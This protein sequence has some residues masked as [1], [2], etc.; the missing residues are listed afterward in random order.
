M[1]I[2]ES[3]PSFGFSLTTQTQ[4]QLPKAHAHR[5]PLRIHMGPWVPHFPAMPNF[6]AA[7]LPEEG[8]YQ[9]LSYLSKEDLVRCARVCKIWYSHATPFIYQNIDF[10]WYHPRSICVHNHRRCIC[11]RLGSCRPEHHGE[12]SYQ[13]SCI[14]TFSSALRE[15]PPLYLFFRTVISSPYLASHVRTLRLDGTVPSSIWTDPQQTELSIEDR[16]CV[17]RLLGSVPRLRHTEEYWMTELDNG[18]PEAFAATLLLALNDLRKIDIGFDFG[19]P[20]ELIGSPTILSCFV[21]LTTISTGTFRDLIHPFNSTNGP[22]LPN[23]ANNSRIALFSLPSLR[24][25]SINMPK[26]PP[27][28]A[29]PW[30]MEEQAPTISNLKTLELAFTDLGGEPL[31]RLLRCCP[32][33]YD[34][35]YDFWTTTQESREDCITDRIN[36]QTLQTTL[37]T[38]KK[39]LRTLHLHI[40][41]SAWRTRQAAQPPLPKPMS[42]LCFADF[43]VLTTL[44]VSVFALTCQENGRKIGPALPAS[45]VDLWLNDDM[46]AWPEWHDDPEPDYDGYY[47]NIFV[48]VIAEYLYEWRVFTPKLKS[49][50]VLVTQMSKP[51]LMRRV[52][53][54]LRNKLTSQGREA[55]V[56]VEVFMLPP[57]NDWEDLK[58]RLL[59]RA[60]GPPYFDLDRVDKFQRIWGEFVARLPPWV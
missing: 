30:S 53:E 18:S 20:L 40:S 43:G 42:P 10:V 22:G 49:L 50:K 41:H 54:T 46:M 7:H 57:R 34:L 13:P 51:L 17:R 56:E 25:L 12:P 23:T 36:L 3:L 27:A 32:Q 38:V 14:E 48:D 8:Y 44:H 5:I 6:G 19:Q 15:Y 1:Q 55:G 31:T 39:M 45:L 60:C 52:T 47:D 11:A 29:F 37:S 2:V 33:L 58:S 9:V 28:S 4:S 35:R 16:C 26:L 24:H 59:F 21:H